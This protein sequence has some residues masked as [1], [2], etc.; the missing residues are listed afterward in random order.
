MKT[1][2]A[3]LLAANIVEAS[4][5]QLPCAPP[6]RNDTPECKRLRELWQ[7]DEIPP[8][9]REFWQPEEKPSIQILPPKP[10]KTTPEKAP[11]S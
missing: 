2:A 1:L 9:R 11:T 5:G 8:R 10:E 4:A 3:L 6:M 7:R